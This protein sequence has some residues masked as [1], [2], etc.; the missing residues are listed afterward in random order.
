MNR[1][2]ICTIA[3]CALFFSPA[4]Q[5]AN[6]FLAASREENKAA[7][8]KTLLPQPLPQKYFK[9]LTTLQRTLHKSISGFARRFKNSP[10]LKDVIL[11]FAGAFLYGIV[12]AAGPGHGKAFAASYFVSRSAALHKGVL[13]GALIACLHAGSAILLVLILKAAASS[14]LLGHVENT[15]RV[16]SLVSYALIA[17]IGTSFLALYS[18]KKL[19]KPKKQQRNAADNAALACTGKSLVSVAF[20]AGI[21]PCPGTTL[22]LIFCLSMGMFSLG[23][24]LAVTVAA[25]MAVTISLA[26]ISAIISRQALLTAALLTKSIR[27]FLSEALEGAG[28]IAIALLGAILF[29]NSL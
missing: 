16:I 12:H 24:L 20:A 13:L 8:Q 4:A 2:L 25:G 10:S 27:H 28:Y 11:L 18:I 6:P 19:R 21:V 3:A 9:A 15:T 17:L 22:L 5:A 29:I 7:A 14:A 23:M 1:L 26:G